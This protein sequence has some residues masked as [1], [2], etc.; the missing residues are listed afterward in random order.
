MLR[1][2]CVIE[3]SC[4]IDKPKITA[5]AYSEWKRV[6]FKELKGVNTQFYFLVF[7]GRKGWESYD[8]S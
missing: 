1:S 4:N 8:Q 2:A 5:I 3:Q 7:G 6:Q